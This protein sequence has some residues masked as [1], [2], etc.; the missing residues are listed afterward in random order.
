MSNKILS[1]SN[2]KLVRSKC[3][4]VMRKI[5]TIYDG[6]FVGEKHY[7]AGGFIVRQLIHYAYPKTIRVTDTY[8][9]DFFLMNRQRLNPH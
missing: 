1:E 3:A 2:L 4:Q 8:D 5:N 6:G 9:I 7:L